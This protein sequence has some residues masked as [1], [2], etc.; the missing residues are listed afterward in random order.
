MRQRSAIRRLMSAYPDQTG[1][2]RE[3]CERLGLDFEDLDEGNGY[4]FSVRDGPRQFIG[5]GGAVTPYPLNGAAAVQVARDKAHAAK[6]LARAGLPVIPGRLC[7]ASARRI[8]LRTPG[9][10]LADAMA[11]IAAERRPVFCKPNGGSGGDFAE[12]VADAEAFA[13]YARRVAPHHEAILIQPVIE[14][15][16]HRVFVLEGVPVYATAKTPVALEG[17]GVSDLVALLETANA[18]LAGRGVSPLPVSIL[19][20]PAHVPAR[21][22]RVELGG[23][24]NL[25]AGGA[26]MVIQPVPVRLAGLAVEACK[27]LG[28]RIGGVDIF[29][30]SAARDHSNLVIIEVNGNPAVTSL[31]QAGRRDLALSLWRDILT[32][33]RRG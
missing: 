25:A 33:W 12:V 18:A 24:R 5:G 31:L 3:A 9:R 4:L 14:G 1:L 32:A 30:R 16:E 2:I 29:D 17:D 11:W 19:S 7:F 23:R 20:D 13:D 10:E 28:L 21:G 26:A 8:R 27:A 6:V 22:E 15:T